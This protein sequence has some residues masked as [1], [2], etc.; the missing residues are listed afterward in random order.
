MVDKRVDRTYFRPYGDFTGD[1]QQPY[2]A[3]YTFIEPSYDPLFNYANGTSQH[4]L[5]SVAA[6]EALI[7]EVYRAIFS[8][9]SGPASALLVV[10][11]EHGGFFD[12][13]PPP[14]AV[15]PGDSPNNYKRAA[16]PRDCKFDRLGPRVP[17]ILVSPW[18]PQG[19]GS[20]EFAGQNFDHASIVHSLRMTFGLKEPLTKRDA[21]ATSWYTALL[22]EPR[23]LSLD[24]PQAS[25]S[26]ALQAAPMSTGVN[27]LG[28]LQLASKLDWDLAG[29]MGVKPL[30]ASPS[31]AAINA[32]DT[33]TGAAADGSLSLEQ[34]QVIVDY[35]GAVQKREDAYLKSQSAGAQAKQ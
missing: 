12:H 22:P 27:L 18:F 21:S 15:P 30:L 7:R 25:A 2:D 26:Q 8:G 10:W 29:R 3:D 4:P 32:I 20:Q 1:M 9:P 6:G 31:N 14:A 33:S 13:V 35:A 34:R 24:L 17:A 23:S 28:T 19:L 16:Q 5:G 11:D